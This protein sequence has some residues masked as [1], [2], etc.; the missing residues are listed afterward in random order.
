[1]GTRTKG[2]QTDRIRKLGAKGLKERQKI[3]L[4]GSG[5]IYTTS[6]FKSSGRYKST[7][8]LG[9]SVVS[10]ANGTWR[11]RGKTITCKFINTNVITSAAGT[12]KYKLRGRNK[13]N[14]VSKLTSDVQSLT[15][16]RRKK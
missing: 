7:M 9:G 3:I 10:I 12:T 2:T 5:P 1:M 13:I 15:T 14:Y 11:L 6:M 8:V 4:P 16:L